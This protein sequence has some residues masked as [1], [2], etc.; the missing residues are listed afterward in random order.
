MRKIFI[1]FMFFICF[2]SL[3]LLIQAENIR[4]YP[5]QPVVITAPGQNPDGIMIK[6]VLE[7]QG[8]DYSYLP[9]LKADELEDYATL[10]LAVGHSCKGVGAAG[11]N[12]EEELVRTKNL[13][14]KAKNEGI[15][16]IITHLGGT[17][18][19]EERSDKL[20]DIS[21]PQADYL[22]ISRES[23]FDSY[24]S[25]AAQE[26][27]IPLAIAEKIS[28]IKPILGNLFKDQSEEIVYFINGDQREPTIFI[29]AGTHGDEI[30]GYQ[31]AQKMLEAVINGGRLI[32]IPRANPAAISA[33]KRNAPG[34]SDLN[35]AFPGNINGNQTEKRAVGIFNLIEEFSPDMVIDLHESEQF[36]YLDKN[37]PGQSLIA[38]QNEE[39]VWQGAVVIESVNEEIDSIKE[40]FVL[41]SYPVEGSLTRAAGENFKIPAYTIETCQKLSLKRRID[42]QI[43]L[44]TSLLSL[45]GVEVRWP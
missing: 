39:T 6:V 34:L 30:A 25:R 32:V 41:L 21:V 22:I 40:R 26:N 43:E 4:V 18:R 20:L 15:F 13:V 8:I 3:S 17:G 37:H 16:L 9:L 5:G 38:Y 19:R 12:F 10:V 28:R 31:A 14:K 36:N 42:Y 29:N 7:Q 2:I 24:F 35:R 44:I 27:N 11:I 1:I 45:Y 33:Y 23:N